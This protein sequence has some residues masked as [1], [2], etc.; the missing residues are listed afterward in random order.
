VADGEKSLFVYLNGVDSKHLAK[1]WSVSGVNEHA[2]TEEQPYV[3]R[4]DKHHPA[5]DR[6]RRLRGLFG[7]GKVPDQPLMA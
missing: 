6:R 5:R 2:N 1:A 3:K 4:I 7:C